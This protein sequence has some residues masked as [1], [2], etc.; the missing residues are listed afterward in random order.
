MLFALSLV[1]LRIL[2]L[3]RQIRHHLIGYLCIIHI[4]LAICSIVYSLNVVLVWVFVLV[5]IIWSF[6]YD[7][8]S[9]IFI[10]LA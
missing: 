8:E 7:Y 2:A 4:F 9:A 3:T 1:K 10:D 6:T 5:F